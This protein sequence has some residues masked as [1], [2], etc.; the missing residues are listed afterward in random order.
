MRIAMGASEKPGRSRRPGGVAALLA[1]AILAGGAWACS[2]DGGAAGWG[3]SVETRPDGAVVVRS[4]ESPAWEEGRGWRLVEDLRI[5]SRDGAGPDAFSSMMSLSLAVAD[6]GSIFVLDG[7]AGEV[8]VFGPAGDHVRT[9]GRAGAGPGEFRAPTL[10][11]WGAEGHLWVVDPGNARYSVFT[12]DGD[13]VTSHRREIS[14]SMAPWPGAVDGA[15]RILDVGIDRAV[16]EPA[17]VRVDPRTAAADTFPLPRYDGGRF[18]QLNEAGLPMRAVS[19]PFAGRLVWKIDPRGYVWSSITDEYRVARAGLGGDTL[20][21]VERAARP[22]RVTAEERADAVERLAEFVASGVPV[23]PSRI[24]TTKPPLHD[25]TVDD[26]GY[27]WVLPAMEDVA[28]GAELGYHV[29]D[30]E[31]RFLGRVPTPTPVAFWPARSVVVRGDH[32]YG[33]TFDEYEVPYLVRL[34]IEGRDGDA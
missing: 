13:Y 11:G 27:L 5:G 30:P 6:D 4:P 16:G 31:G 9:F 32:L 33:F 20:L 3:G 10:A 24:P 1:G 23:D 18:V 28:D 26:Q 2:G 15:G 14:Y 7:Q 8:R 29:F 12:A 25:F 34:R 17:L 19:I 22:L 21:I